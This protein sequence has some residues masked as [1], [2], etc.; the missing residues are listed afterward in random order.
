[1]FKDIKGYIS[2]RIKNLEKNQ[3]SV[4]RI[5]TSLEIFLK[6]KFGEN[7]KGFSLKLELN[8]EN[9]LI[10]ESQNKTIANEI[11]Y[12]KDDLKTYLAREN[13]KIKAIIIK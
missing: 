9:D 1:M 13:S 6:N 11:A 3:N 7:L 4:Q 12:L 5:K 8:K 10:I 2:L